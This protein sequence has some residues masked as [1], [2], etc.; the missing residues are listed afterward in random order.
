MG[1]HD[2]SLLHFIQKFKSWLSL[3]SNPGFCDFE[4][5][6]KNQNICHICKTSELKSDLNHHCRSCGSPL[7]ENCVHASLDGA[8]SCKICFELSLS[9]KIGR[10]CSGKVYPSQSPELPSPSFSGERFGCNSQNA[11]TRSSDALLSNHPS[12][13]SERC[14]T[15]RIDKE[16]DEHSTSHLSD[17]LHDISDVDS[18]SVNSA[19]HE[20]YNSMSLGSPS[21]LT[22]PSRLHISSSR[23]GPYLQTDDPIDRE[24]AILENPAKA[25]W[26]ANESPQHLDFEPNGLIWLPPPPDDVDD[27]MENKLFT[28]DDE[29]DNVGDSGFMFSPTDNMDTVFS[30]KEKRDLY[31]KETWRAAVEGHFRALVSHLLQGEGI[32]VTIGDEDW[33]DIVTA[34]SWQAAKFI[35]PNTSRGGSMDP[36]DYLKIK[37]VASGNRGESKLIKGVVC[38][39]NIKHKR[40]TSQ[41]KNARLLILGGALEYQRVPNQLASFETLLQ[42]ENDHL[43]TLVSKIEA[44]RPNILIVEKSVSSFA[45]EHL[46]AKDISLVL[47]VKRPLLERIARCTGASITPSTEH[48]S[49]TRLG[50]CELFRLE[51][52]P[53]EHEP[54]NQFNKKPT[55]TLMFFEGCPRRLGCTVV[56]RGSYREELKKVKHVLQ[57]AVFAAY[58]LS[59][60]T[61]FLA[62]EGANL[63]KSP[64]KALPFAPETM[65]HNKDTTHS[66]E[67]T[68]S[69]I[70]LLSADLNLELGLQESLS[71]LGESNYDDI[72]MQNDFRYREALSEACD[73]NL[74]L[75]REVGPTCPRIGNNQ[76]D[77]SEYYSAN[78]T[79]Q[80][81]LVS[82]SSHCVTN[83]I[84]CERSR[85]IRLKF[86]GH[87]DKPLGRYLRDDLFDQS[88]VCRSCK[89]PAEAHVVSYTHQHANL[90]ISVKR[91]P[92]V[93]LPGE[94]DGKIWMWHRCLR[95]AHIDGVPPATP[96]VVMSDAAW[97]LS[98]GKFLELSFSSH[99]TGNRL[100]SCGHSL[101]RDCL[102]FY[103]FGNMIAFFRYSPINILSVRLPPSVLEFSGPGEQSWIRNESNELLSKA[104]ALHAEIS[105]FLEEFK[106]KSSSFVDEYVNELHDHILD[107][108]DM[109]SHEKNY[110][111]DLLETSEHDQASLDIFEINHLRHSLLIGSQVWNRRLYL[112]DALLKSSTSKAQID[113][114]TLFGL[115]DYEIEHNIPEHPELE[116]SKPFINED[117]ENDVSIKTSLERHPSAA[118]ILSDKIDSAWSGADLAPLNADLPNPS[119]RRLSGPT[120]VY[121]FDS[122]QRLRERVRTSSF[123]LSKIRS[124]HASGDYRHMV[125]DPVN[126]KRT[127]SQL[128]LPREAEKL[129]ISPSF[130]SLT[131]D[132]KLMVAQNDVIIAVYENE[133]SSII[134]YALSSKDYEDLVVDFKKVNSVASNLSTLSSIS[135]LDLDYTNYENVQ[136]NSSPHVRISFEEDKI[137]FS[138]TCYFGRQFDSLRKKCCPSEVDFIRSLSR[139]KKW[140]AQGGKSNV[141]FAKSFDDRFIIKQVTKT[142][143]DSFGEFANGYFKYLTDAVSSGGPTCLAKVLGIYQVTVKHMKGGKE[144]KM[145]LMVMENIFFGRNISKVYDLKG[146]ARSRYNPDTIGPNKVLLDMNLLET[147]R[148]NPIFL[149][150]KAKRILERAVWNDTSFLASVDVMDYSLLVGVD[151]DRKELVMGIIDFMR[152]YTWDKHLETWVKASG[153][154]GGP[155]NASPTII[156]PKQYKKRFRKAMTTYF[157]TVPDQW[158]S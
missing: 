130:I 53:E 5:M 71:E 154:L 139:C 102:R 132:S 35:K 72:S 87:S 55:K 63:P 107:L 30:D 32:I 155:K 81:I 113:L 2:S 115:K 15:S 93:K 146:S 78:E 126:M 51:K 95:C 48:I 116:E 144:V 143:L 6:D 153:I 99:T 45:L 127:H 111:K 34:I 85:L 23:F 100:A 80:S 148:T 8:S 135:S 17:F 64:L 140:S 121:S 141:Y 134:S 151:E 98:F 101:Q 138:V 105:G 18:S 73:E 110:F 103:G 74:A 150:S 16:E 90:T 75:D 96:R 122:A 61:S 27:E 149:G 76:T 89:E 14:S 69:N 79:H 37:C 12:P 38:T 82:F 133:P 54:V 24:R 147:L 36:C 124:F 40:M 88:N 25:N 152:Q 20:F 65:T 42:Q 145:D 1:M 28:Y 7:C 114:Q 41:Y 157:L 128:L 21:P 66:E 59:L 92:S 4:T 56:L 70:K 91:V 112:L 33:V 131:E 10:K 43:K 22:S 129:N 60:E 9:S 3:D 26:A 67:I 57:Y 13:G 137:K 125:R 106:S 136:N 86:Y 44:H 68:L 118:S 58:H 52:V 31:H 19:R 142:E 62:D 47:N 83:G 11:L 49:T 50:H 117:E 29:D 120:R 108:N 77:D 39:K 46:L 104:R 84:V 156:S 97:G 119:I 109:L 158:S 123:Y 94:Q